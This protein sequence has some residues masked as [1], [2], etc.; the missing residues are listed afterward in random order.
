MDSELIAWRER[1]A[2]CADL[3]LMA[4][5]Q[6]LA[7]FDR[8]C[9]ARMLMYLAEVELRKLHCAQG[10]GSLFRFAVAELRMSEAQ[11]YL[12]I[13]AARL[14]V[15]YPVVI[16][17][18]AQGSVNLSTLK[19]LYQ[20]LT[21]KNHADLLARARG[22]TKDEVLQLVAALA[23]RPDVP[24]RIRKLP[25]KRTADA[26]SAAFSVVDHSPELVPDVPAPEVVPTVPAAPMV[27]VAPAAPS[28]PAGPAV[29]AL[30]IPRATCKPLRPGRF[31]LELTASQELRDKLTR[32]QHLLQHQVPGGDLGAIV[33]RAIDELLE[34]TLK[35]RFAQ[36]AKPKSKTRE[37]SAGTDAG[38]GDAGDEGSTKRASRYV[39]RAV[40]REVFARD[41]EQCSFVSASGHRCSERGML[42]V[43]HVHPF[44][45]GG[46]AT[47]AN[48][49]LVCRAHNN[50]FAEQ[51]F[52]ATHMRLKRSASTGG[53]QFAFF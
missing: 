10:Y 30:E 41:G 4:E 33:E 17:M 15:R 19:L 32:L 36:V 20:H 28:A 22:K 40:V 13:Q 43:H 3:Q 42:E 5:L 47:A 21:D 12:R 39:P 2:G 16:E 25:A 8:R 7:R 24:N 6:R 14:A 9:E 37:E 35:K 48:L 53:D 1:V 23:P 11:A 34:Q 45:R 44:A 51:D 18:L 49:R 38:E 27:S 50:W 46:E 26:R 31:K 29:F 52:G